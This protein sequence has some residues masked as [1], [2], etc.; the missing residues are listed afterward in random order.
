[1][2]F[3]PGKWLKK[4][5]SFPEIAHKPRLQ[6]R[7][8][9]KMVVALIQRCFCLGQKCL[10]LLEA[11][12]LCAVTAGTLLA[13]GKSQTGMLIILRCPGQSY[14]I[15][16]CTALNSCHWETP[17]GPGT[18]SN[19][20]LKPPQWLFLP[21]MLSINGQICE[22]VLFSFFLSQSSGFAKTDWSV[23]HRVRLLCPY[24][25]PNSLLD[26]QRLAWKG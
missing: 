5:E 1:M 8:P 13:F 18:A 22:T 16:N 25:P 24:M 7:A 14:T 17:A 12:C 23:K 9:G 2:C 20:R 15:M 21:K 19:Q 10:G 11:L 26:V 3:L 6:G 4:L